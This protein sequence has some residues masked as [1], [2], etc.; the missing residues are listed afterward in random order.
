MRTFK[1]KLLLVLLGFLARV[2]IGRMLAGLFL[3]PVA[4]LFV[5]LDIACV[6]VGFST[7]LTVA[8]G[9]LSFFFTV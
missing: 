5:F 3:Q 4:Y 8:C 6:L 7:S 1:D 9:A 2:A